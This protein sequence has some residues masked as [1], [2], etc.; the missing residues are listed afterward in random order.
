MDSFITKQECD[1]FLRST[2]HQPLA[3]SLRAQSSRLSAS[4]QE[5]G[6]DLVFGCRMAFSGTPS[7]LLPRELGICRYEEVRLLCL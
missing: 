7:D 5:L 4:G 6:G 2:L 3:C 1:I